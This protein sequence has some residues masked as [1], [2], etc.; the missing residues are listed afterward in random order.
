MAFD[1]FMPHIAYTARRTKCPRYRLHYTMRIKL[2]GQ[3]ISDVDAEIHRRIISADNNMRAHNAKKYAIRLF[4][5][6]GKPRPTR[7]L[8]VFTISYRAYK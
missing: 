2:L 8:M 4:V 5:R 6:I 7:R 1:S 3:N